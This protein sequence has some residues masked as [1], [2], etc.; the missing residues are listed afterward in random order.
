[1][2]RAA[3][4]GALA[5]LLAA[6][7]IG[8]GGSGANFT[9]TSAN[10][11]NALTAATLAAFSSLTA[12][13]SG[14]DVALSWPAGGSGVGY[15]VYGASNGSSSTCASAPTA[16]LGGSSTP[17]TSWTDSA[18]G[19]AAPGSWWCYRVQAVYHSWTSISGDPVAATRT[20]VAVNSVTI[21]NGA[22]SVSGCSSSGTAQALDCGDRIQIVFDQPMQQVPAA[23]STDTVC[24]TSNTIMLGDT[25]TSGGCATTDPV[26]VGTLTGITTTNNARYSAS[27]S[28][29][30]THD[31]L[32]IV[33]GGLVAGHKNVVLGSG[34]WTFKP[35]TT[36]TKLLSATGSVHACDQNTTG[37]VGCTPAA[38]GG[39]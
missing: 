35:T 19:A 25:V 10:P 30:A 37:G 31:T 4:L 27:W 16:A 9:G 38:S 5:V 2:R 24:G 1:M 34:T 39:F 7:A 20:G 18:R 22:S 14:N 6:G 13:P 21:T 32:T 3:G 11:A 23:S 12:A 29:N 17:A 28:W 8:W 26:E 15:E 36:S 33:L